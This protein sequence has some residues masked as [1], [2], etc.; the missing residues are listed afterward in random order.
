MRRIFKTVIGLFSLNLLALSVAAQTSA[1]YPPSANN[2][3]CFARVL[4]PEITE[5]ISEQ[6]E[7]TAASTQQIIVPAMYETQNVRVLV[8]EASTSFRTVPAV[9]KTVTEDIL[10]EPESETLVAIPATY[11]TWTE[12]EQIEPAKAV[13]KSGN[14][15]YGRGAAGTGTAPSAGDEVATG[16]LL[17]RVMEPAKTR[18]V[19]H[20]RM[21]APP[22]TERRVIPAKFKTVSRQ[23]VSIPPRVEEIPIPTEY[24][25]IPVSVMVSPESTQI[26]TIPA[27]YRTVERKVLISS[28]GLQ[29]AEVL[30]ET[31]TT[32]AQVATI[33]RGLTAAGYTTAADG[34]FGPQTQ[35]SMEAFQRANGLAVGYMTVE[36]VR[37]LSLDPYV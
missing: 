21:T 4:A 24:L 28:G 2:G 34:A 1:Q 20:T 5:T 10:S 7:V 26:E 8:K 35:R 29:W 23:V 14:G 30:C 18:T 12:V 31:N 15:L 9:Y 25:D 11:E 32:R 16:E 33:Q 36:T 22:R 13:W 6:V 37:A 17:C 19:R 27:T 3:Q